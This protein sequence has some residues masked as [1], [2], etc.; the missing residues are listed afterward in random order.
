MSILT[1]CHI[2]R[3]VTFGS[4]AFVA[5]Q[6]AFQSQ[7]IFAWVFAWFDSSALALCAFLTIH[8]ASFDYYDPMRVVG[9]DVT[10]VKDDDYKKHVFE[11]NSDGRCEEVQIDL[12][13]AFGGSWA[14]PDHT[15]SDDELECIN[16]AMDKMFNCHLCG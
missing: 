6:P 12:K 14:C 8:H 9:Y 7:I 13:V 3:S 16:T 2:W 4:P 5:V 1:F 11:Y 10:I 15:D